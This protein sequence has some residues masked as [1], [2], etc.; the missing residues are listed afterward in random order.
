MYLFPEINLK[1][2]PRLLAQLKPGTRIVSHDFDMA[3]WAPDATA[4]LY[5]AEK[6]GAT[7]GESTIYLWFVPAD[8]A[9]RWTWR[10][11]IGGQPVDYELTAAQRFQKVDARLRIG[12]QSRPVQ[13]V[14]LRGDR[15]SFT[16]VSEIKGSTVRQEFSGRASGDGIEGSVIL[17]GPRMQGAADWVAQRSERAS[18]AGALAPAFR[19]VGALAPASHFVGALTPAFRFVGALA[20]ASRSINQ[21]PGARYNVSANEAGRALAP[22]TEGER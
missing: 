18:D 16:V 6:Y 22:P 17:S 10:L 5:S 7:G 20:P 19:F 11:E 8:I 4:K 1:L 2:R 14:R 15:I 3:D 13:D 9:G 21:A 12:G